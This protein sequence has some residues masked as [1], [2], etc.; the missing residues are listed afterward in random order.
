MLDNT[1]RRRSPHLRKFRNLKASAGFLRSR[2]GGQLMGKIERL[3]LESLIMDFTMSL[4]RRATCMRFQ[5][6]SVI[7]SEDMTQI[8]AFGYNGS[9]KGLS[10]DDCRPDR[11]AR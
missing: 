5:A 3:S 6:G 11:Q 10:H 2:P 1:L 7:T 8:Y 9:A 4:T